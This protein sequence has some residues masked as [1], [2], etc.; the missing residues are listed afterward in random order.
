M[1]KVFPFIVNYDRE[2]RMEVDIWR[3]TKVEKTIQFAKMIKRIQKEIGVVPRKVQEEI[4][5]QADKR[6]R[7]IKE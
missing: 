3:K 6:R 2:L 1:I 5:Q 4:K 7:E